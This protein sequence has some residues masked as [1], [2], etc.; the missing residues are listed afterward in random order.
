MN[1]DHKLWRSQWNNIIKCWKKKKTVNPEFQFQQKYPLIKKFFFS[2]ERKQRIWCL[3]IFTLRNTEGSSLGRGEMIP[4]ENGFSGR[5]EYLKTPNIWVKMNWPLQPPRQHTHSSAWHPTPLTSTPQHVPFCSI[6]FTR[7][8][9]ELWTI[10]HESRLQSLQMLLPLPKMFRLP[11]SFYVNYTHIYSYYKGHPVFQ[12]TRLHQA[13][14]CISVCSSKK[15]NNE[16]KY[17]AKT[18]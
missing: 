7:D 16:L 11:S 10:S 18:L 3:K 12:A 1:S 9:C 6:S 13:L 4:K 5:N 15:E 2:H 17:I 14:L 8:T